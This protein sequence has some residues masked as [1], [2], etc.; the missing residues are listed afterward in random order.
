MCDS[1]LATGV[2]AKRLRP[3]AQARDT[4]SISVHVSSLEWMKLEALEKSNH[5]AL[6]VQLERGVV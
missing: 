3:E 6:R 1:V 4:V 2:G 5:K